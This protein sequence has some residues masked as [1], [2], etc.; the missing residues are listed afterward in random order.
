MGV[1]REAAAADVDVLVKAPV[2][3]LVPHQGQAEGLGQDLLG[4]I[5]HRGAKAAGRDDHVGARLRD[6]HAGAQ[7]LGV[8]ADDRVILDVDADLREHLGDVPRVG[9]RDMAE[10]DLRTDGDDLGDDFLIHIRSGS[11]PGPRG[12]R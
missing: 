8:V 10:Q 1:G 5:V 7:A 3:R 11:F 4:Q 12:P 2:L 9:V 6:L